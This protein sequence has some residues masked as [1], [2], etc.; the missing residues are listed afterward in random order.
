MK[1]FQVAKRKGSRVLSPRTCSRSMW[2]DV[3]RMA[4]SKGEQGRRICNWRLHGR[5]VRGSISERCFSCLRRNKL[6]YVG[7]VGTGLTKARSRPFAEIPT[8]DSEGF[9]RLRRTSAKKNATFLSPQFV[10][11]VS[12][13]E[14]TTMESCAIPSMSGYGTTKRRKR[15]STGGLGERTA[16]QRRSKSRILKRYSGQTRAIPSKTRC[17]YQEYFHCFALTSQTEFYA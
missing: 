16:K 1:A 6:R 7:K 17:F 13:T 14:W 10:A 12:F 15:W 3:L 5:L 9:L 2:R 4:Q 8:A 11:Q